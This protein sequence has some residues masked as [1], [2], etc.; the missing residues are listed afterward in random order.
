MTPGEYRRKSVPAN[1]L[2]HPS[3]LG[4][5]RHQTINSQIL[6]PN[7]A[8]D[9]IGNAEGAYDV[10]K[11][12]SIQEDDVYKVPINNAPSFQVSYSSG[13]LPPSIPIAFSQVPT[14]SS[15]SISGEGYVP[16]APKT[17]PSDYIPF[18]PKDS[19]PKEL[20]PEK[21]FAPL[22]YLK[23]TKRRSNTLPNKPVQKPNLPDRGNVVWTEIPE[24][25][26][27]P[28]NTSE[29]TQYFTGFLI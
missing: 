13:N 15:Q 17:E 18:L 19:D 16:M 23:D 6:P 14:K 7:N 11:G 25:P 22:S 27:K 28:L 29:G 5:G 3:I 10:I 8:T 20:S 12:S 21:K 26:S 9:F 4:L 1:S 24:V 2:R